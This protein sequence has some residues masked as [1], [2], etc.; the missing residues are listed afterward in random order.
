MNR[1]RR[2]EVIKYENEAYV[3][4]DPKTGRMYVN[5]VGSTENEVAANLSFIDIPMDVAERLEIV[6]CRV[7]VHAK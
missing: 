1:Y 4:R 2:A 7:V 5:A 3:A 6:P